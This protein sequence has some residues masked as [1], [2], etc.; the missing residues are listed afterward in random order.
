MGLEHLQHVAEEFEKNLELVESPAFA[1]ADPETQ[2]TLLTTADNPAKFDR[3]VS[4]VQRQSGTANA[5][6]VCTAAGL[7]NPK[8]VRDMTAGEINKAL[9][10][11]D[12]KSSQLTDKFIKAGRGN[13]RPSDYLSKSD[14]LST[15]ARE[16]HEARRT[17]QIEKEMRYGPGAPHHL[18][19]G[20]GPRKRSNPES[21]AASLSETFHG[22][23]ADTVTEII[24]DIHTHEWLA[25]LGLL[26]SLT[27]ETESGYEVELEFDYNTPKNA[28]RVGMSED[29]RQL[30]FA[31]GDQ[32]LNLSDIHMDGRKW[33]R[34]RMVI[35]KVTAYAYFTSKAQDG[36]KPTIYTHEAGEDLVDGKHRIVTDIMPTLIY[37]NV[38]KLIEFAGGMYHV[39]DEA[40]IR[41]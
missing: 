8:D 10:R 37:D 7:R 17:L 14:A 22:R 26:V 32:A 40:G 23:P 5:Y 18:P 24:T 28:V 11:I 38:N 9:D 21:A 35:G 29:G 30:Y 15:K 39:S 4:D 20:F 6:A 2:A 36:N 19:K 27:L 31:G 1:N 12:A 13:E 41:S 3:C 33:V 25:E 16:L 34:D